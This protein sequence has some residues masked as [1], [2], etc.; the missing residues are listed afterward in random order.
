VLKINSR[1]LTQDSIYCYDDQEE[2]LKILE[3]MRI[4][5]MVLLRAFAKEPDTGQVGM[6][7]SV[8]QTLSQRVPQVPQN[9]LDG[10]IDDLRQMRLINQ[11]NT[12]ITMTGSGANDLR[13]I[14]NERGTR[15]FEYLENVDERVIV[16]ESGSNIP[17]LQKIEVTGT[18][19][20]AP[21]I[22]TPVSIG[23]YLG[24]SNSIS[25]FWNQAP[26]STSNLA[27]TQWTW[28]NA[29]KPCPWFRSLQLWRFAAAS[30]SARTS[31]SDSKAI[32][33]CLMPTGPNSQT[34]AKN[35]KKNNFYAAN[36]SADG[37]DARQD[38]C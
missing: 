6:M 22:T 4:E 3:R 30:G 16:L 2:M 31:T 32:E 34:E 12:T 17:V 29:L 9:L 28:P 26:M 18:R 23:T 10:L 8:G 36:Y 11:V 27:L 7:G 25:P 33:T 19:G 21:A 15:I 14:V 5:H 20:T 24:I 38:H 35:G 13:H 1:L 37:Q